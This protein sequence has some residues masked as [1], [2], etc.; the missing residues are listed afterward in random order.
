MNL[1]YKSTYDRPLVTIIKSSE[2]Q[3]TR[4]KKDGDSVDSLEKTT[5]F[6]KLMVR[7]FYV[8]GIAYCLRILY[9]KLR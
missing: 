7:S 6:K 4:K 8:V 2:E 9:N 3:D 5:S 1:D